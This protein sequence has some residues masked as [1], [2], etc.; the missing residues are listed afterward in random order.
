MLIKQ[1]L[2]EILECHLKFYGLCF[3]KPCFQS[4]F[5]FFHDGIELQ[6]SINENRQ[7]QLKET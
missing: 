2:V 1:S 6:K 5:C 7:L 3:I 4:S